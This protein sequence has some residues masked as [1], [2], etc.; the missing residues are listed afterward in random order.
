MQHVKDKMFR[1]HVVFQIEKTIFSQN[2][3]EYLGLQCMNK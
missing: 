3:F 2:L 1:T